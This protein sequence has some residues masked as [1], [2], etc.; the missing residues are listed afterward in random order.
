MSA[1]GNLIPHPYLEASAKT[2]YRQVQQALFDADIAMPNLECVVAPVP[3]YLARM[4]SVPPLREAL[5]TLP[6][7]ARPPTRTSHQNRVSSRSETAV[8][9]LAPPLF[10][11]RASDQRCREDA[12]QPRRLADRMADRRPVNAPVSD[13][14]GQRERELLGKRDDGFPREASP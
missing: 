14:A 1:E 12:A 3:P 6:S 10:P 7:T 13:G 8:K 9:C 5:T 4:V 11:P 2:L